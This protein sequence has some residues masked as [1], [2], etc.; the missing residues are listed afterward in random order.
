MTVVPSDTD[1]IAERVRQ[2]FRA[3]D[4]EALG[5]LLHP[6]V[7]WGDHHYPDA[8]C[9]NRA[10]VLTWFRAH[11]GEGVRAHMT[12][13]VAHEDHVLIV[14]TVTGTDA[15]PGEAGGTP[16]WQVLTVTGGRIVDIR[17]YEDRATAASA[18]G[19]PG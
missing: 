10:E 13:V 19:L 8:G 5:D 18:I 1:R 17:G 16:R 6:D 14:V 4:L 7:R 12:E 2:S 9:Q 3:D 11:R 15:Q